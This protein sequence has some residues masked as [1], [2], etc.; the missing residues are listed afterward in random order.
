MLRGRPVI[1]TSAGGVQQVVVDGRTGLFVPP[2]DSGA[3]ATRIIELLDDPLR[4]RAM[5]Q[6]GRTYVLEEFPVDRM[7]EQTA[8]LYRDVLGA[9]PVAAG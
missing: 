9:V 1:A 3:L 7:V 2:R 5:G 6:A 8:N 4:A